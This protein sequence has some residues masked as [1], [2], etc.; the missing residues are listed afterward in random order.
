MSAKHRGGHSATWEIPD[1]DVV[2]YHTHI[3]SKKDVIQ[4]VTKQ[5]IRRW[6]R[7]GSRPN[8][9][10]DCEVMHIV[11]ALIKDRARRAGCGGQ[12]EC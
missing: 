6:C 5:I 2:D 7:I 8:H 12:V 4:K 3:N 11:A 1:D 9:E 10:W